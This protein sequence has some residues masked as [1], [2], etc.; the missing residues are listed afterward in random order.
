MRG[1]QGPDLPLGAAALRGDQ[2][3]HLRAD[4]LLLL[5]LRLDPRL[6]S[7]GVIPGEMPAVSGGPLPDKPR[8]LPLLFN[9][10][11]NVQLLCPCHDF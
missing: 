5:Q 8:A 11:V 10:R 4:A 1:P 9:A 2:G 7:A 3:L 6:L